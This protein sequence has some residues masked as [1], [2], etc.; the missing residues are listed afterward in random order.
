[1]TAEWIMRPEK[2]ITDLAEIPNQMGLPVRF[3]AYET[4]RTW[5]EVRAKNHG[6][7]WGVG[8]GINMCD[9]L[10]NLLS[11]LGL[12]LTFDNPENPEARWGKPYRGFEDR[13]A[14]EHIGWGYVY[15]IRGLR[16]A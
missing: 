12:E 1:M 3:T 14:L 11:N 16:H 6:V 5:W 7:D 4:D 13:V 9:A 8:I 2:P 15:E 10:A